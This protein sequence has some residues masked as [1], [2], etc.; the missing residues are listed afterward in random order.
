MY[1]GNKF[2]AIAETAVVTDKVDYPFKIAVLTDTHIT[3]ATSVSFVEKLVR[4]VNGLKPDV[5]VLVGDIADAKP[6]SVD[7]QME[8]LAK[9]EA[10]YGVFV[11]LGNHEFYHG[12]VEW[13]KKFRQMRLFYL[14][15][16]GLN[17]NGENVYIFGLPDPQLLNISDQTLHG[18]KNKMQSD[19]KGAYRIFLSHS[20]RFIKRLIYRF[21]GIRMV[22]KSFRFIF[23]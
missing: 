12:S 22:G 11:T 19:A 13:E 17:L 10:R 5:T 6:S 14:G 21:R 20:P 16:E 8:A 18:I 9:L 2:P 23:W 7:A 3:P 15:G 4:T 1:E